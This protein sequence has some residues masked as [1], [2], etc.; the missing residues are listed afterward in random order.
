MFVACILI[1]Q[2][3]KK[4][5]DAASDKI[6]GAVNTNYGGPLQGETTEDIKKKEN[7][8]K[9]VSYRSSQFP[10]GRKLSYYQHIAD[11]QWK[12]LEAFVN[13]DEDKLI[14]QVAS[15]NTDELKAVYKCFGLK[16]R[17]FA[18][19]TVKSGDLFDF[20]EDV[21]SDG[22]LAGDDLSRMRKVWAKT[23]LW[24]AD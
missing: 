19:L 6:E 22:I 5:W 18:K 24:A 23:G 4:W 12:E 3:L 13:T 2:M 15:L 21:L 10:K 14:A 17:T 11:T 20:Y 16:E 7:L 9:Q 8:I 1:F